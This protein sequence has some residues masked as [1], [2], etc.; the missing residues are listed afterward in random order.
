[1]NNKLND[2]TKNC[3]LKYKYLVDKIKKTILLQN[4]I[5]NQI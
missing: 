2:N 4:K 1:M 3:K 5:N